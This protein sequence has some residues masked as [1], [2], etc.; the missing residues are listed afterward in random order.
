MKKATSNKIEYED[1][2]YEMRIRD[3]IGR[4]KLIARPHALLNELLTRS[5]KMERIVFDACDEMSLDFEDAPAWH[6]LNAV[7][8]YIGQVDNRFYV[9][10]TRHR[11]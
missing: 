2:F 4:D 7:S 1:G 9:R 6:V 8:D 5:A 3:Y 10:L 11:L